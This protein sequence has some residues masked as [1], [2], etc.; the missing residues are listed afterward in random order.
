MC[1]FYLTKGTMCLYNKDRQVW[2]HTYAG[3]V[4]MYTKRDRFIMFFLMSSPARVI[5]DYYWISSVQNEVRRNERKGLS[6]ALTVLLV[7]C[8]LG[9]YSVVWQ[10]R[11]SGIL[12]K[13][14]AHE[15]RFMMAIFAVL[16]IGVFVNPLIIQGQ[17]NKLAEQRFFPGLI[18]TSIK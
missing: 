2:K 3:G 5:F 13:Q 14:G 10:F 18:H 1:N 17:I 9:V 11:T 8:T 16:L 15:K 12:K 6:G 7:I 4:K